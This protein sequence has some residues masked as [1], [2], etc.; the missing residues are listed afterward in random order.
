MK[1]DSSLLS[2]VIT[3]ILLFFGCG[4]VDAASW[5]IN[6]NA[7]RHAHFTSIN[8]AMDSGDVQDGDTLYLD[9][10]CTLTSTQTVSK[11]V[12]IIGTGYSL[13]ENCGIQ[14]A[15]INGALY[16]TAAGIKVEAVAVTNSKTTTWYVQA[17]NITIER[18]HNH[19]ISV[20]AQYATIR[21]CRGF[22]YYGKGKDKTASAYCTIENCMLG[23]STAVN[24]YD[25]MSATIR[26]N[27]LWTESSSTSYNGLLNNLGGCVVVN[28]IIVGSQKPDILL[29]PANLTDCVVTN[30]VMSCAEGT[31]PAFPD[32]ICLGSNT[33]AEVFTIKLV[34]RTL[35][36][37]D[38]AGVKDLEQ[39]Q[40]AATDGGNCG[41]F[42]GAYP[43]VFSGYPLGIPHFVSSSANTVAVDKKVSFS[44]EVTIQKQ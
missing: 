30:N 8:A 22:H 16:L 26:N 33:V 34:D 36:D 9:P 7:N 19:F 43:Y 35:S 42:G 15:A 18:C 11:Q 1:R 2:T 29:T 39:A 41:P 3:A 17:K 14:V 28:N 40:G 6:N 31:Y 23:T 5:R 24:I 32:N 37:Q 38:F 13:P 12:T 27:Y 44:N 25:L 10:G 20:E 4:Y 21:Q